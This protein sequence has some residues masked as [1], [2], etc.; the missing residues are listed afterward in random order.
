VL[1]H[2]A[3]HRLLVERLRGDGT[4]GFSNARCWFLTRD[5][6]LPRYALATLDGSHVDLPFCV[7]PPRGCRSCGRSRP[8][9]RTSTSRWWSF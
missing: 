4:V 7:G 5:T 9:P 8:A 6:K 3:K 2:D 1:E